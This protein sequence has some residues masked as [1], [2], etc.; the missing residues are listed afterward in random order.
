M[1]AKRLPT[2]TRTASEPAHP[3]HPP[4][5]IPRVLVRLATLPSRSRPEITLRPANRKSQ[6][7]VVALQSLKGQRLS[8]YGGSESRVSP[9]WARNPSM[10]SGRCRMRLSLACGLPAE[11]NSVTYYSGSRI[12]SATPGSVRIR[13]EWPLP[14]VSSM[15]TRSPGSNCRELPSLAVISARPTRTTKN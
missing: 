10:S 9:V 7:A 8:R 13:V 6:S 2:A 11:T 12:T 14:E 1:L 4:R 3:R 15:R 5:R